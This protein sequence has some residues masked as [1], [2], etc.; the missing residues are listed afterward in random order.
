MTVCREII[1]KYNAGLSIAACPSQYHPVIK[2]GKDEILHLY[3]LYQ[4]NPSWQLK[5]YQKRLFL[6][7]DLRVVGK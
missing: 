7:M 1:G 5:D 2:M 4:I 3:E 6:D